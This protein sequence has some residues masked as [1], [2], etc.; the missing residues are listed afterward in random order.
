MKFLSSI[1]NKLEGYRKFLSVMGDKGKKNVYLQYIRYSTNDLD[2][3]G[4]LILDDSQKEMLDKI[5]LLSK[6]K[7]DQFGNDILI[8]VEKKVSYIE[9]L[10]LFASADCFL[11]TSKQE[12]FS[13]GLYEFLILKQF[14]K[15]EKKICYM[16][17]ELSGVNT[18][19]AGTIKI[20]P[21]DYNSIYNGFIQSDQIMFGEHDERNILTLEKDF[22]HVMKSS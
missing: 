7:K 13:L 15:Q 11:R 14:L 22:Q 6:K 18:S 12:S 21:F 3:N 8:L 9:R 17:S 5:H 10:A 4:N 1:K 2:K 19:L 16:L 20:N